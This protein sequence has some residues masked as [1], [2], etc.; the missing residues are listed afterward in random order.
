MTGSNVDP[1]P[2]RPHSASR[3]IIARGN[4]PTRVPAR[5]SSAC[6]STIP[7]RGLTSR[8]GGLATGACPAVITAR[9]SRALS[10]F[11]VSAAFISAMSTRRPARFTMEAF[12][13]YKYPAWQRLHIPSEWGTSLRSHFQPAIIRVHPGIFLP[14]PNRNQPRARGW[15]APGLRDPAGNRMRLR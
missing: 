2:V 6:Y 10:S 13:R 3:H 1:L 9:I 4:W 7:K 5:L 15:T 12:S 14:V 11:N 8:L